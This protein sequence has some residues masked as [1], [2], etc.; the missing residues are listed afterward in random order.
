[1]EML[2]IKWSLC[3]ALLL[4]PIVLSAQT[5]NDEQ[6]QSSPVIMEI[7]VGNDGYASQMIINKGFSAIPRL[8]FFSVTNISSS[9]GEKLSQDAMNQINLKYDFFKGM[10]V[11]GGVH[12]TP[13]TGLRPTTALMYTKGSGTF[14]FMVSPRLIGF[15]EGGIIEGFAMVE[16]KPTINEN[17]SIYSRLQG[18]YNQTISDGN[19]A[20]SYLMLR[21]G[22]SYKDFSFGLGANW[23]AF[24]AEKITKENYG[25]FLSAN[26]FN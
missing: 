8:G 11:F 16:Y 9:W 23:D 5:D 25:V 1:M 14:V 26:L 6:K 7:L 12:Y 2:F 19:H 3:F 18:L 21:T 4:P 15:N 13:V 24:G 17:W 10:G 20:R 22:V